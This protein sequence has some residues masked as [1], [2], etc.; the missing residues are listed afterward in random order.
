ML[1]RIVMS[2]LHAK[3]Q[4]PLSKHDSFPYRGS[5]PIKSPNQIFNQ[6]IETKLG[7]ACKGENHI[8]RTV[9]TIHRAE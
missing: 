1:H 4:N 3:A 2:D 7:R 6:I 8:K 5:K 9:I